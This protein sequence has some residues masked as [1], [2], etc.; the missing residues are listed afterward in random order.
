MVG[1]GGVNDKQTP[2]TF[3]MIRCNKGV[4]QTRRAPEDLCQSRADTVP[5][6]LPVIELQ[7]K[8]MQD[9]VVG[10]VILASDLRVR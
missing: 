3:V 6:L 7:L 2:V 9:P 1:L 10:K 5:R 4:L 8:L